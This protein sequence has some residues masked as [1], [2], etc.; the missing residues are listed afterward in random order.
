MG[1]T[2]E[3]SGIPW[4]AWKRLQLS[5]ADGGLGFR[6]LAKFNDALL[7][8]QAWRLL[9]YPNSLCARVLK[10]RYYLNDSILEAKP[11]SYQSFGWASILEGLD[12]IKKGT[13]HIVGD[14][15]LTQV[16][17]ENIL[18]SHPPRPI[19]TICPEL[20]FPIFRLISQHGTHRFLDERVISSMILPQDRTLLSQIHLSREV[21]PNYLIW[22]M[23]NRESIQSSR[24]IGS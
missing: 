22:N 9:R 23:I 15:H 13:R 18:G 7:A 8:K 24:V 10:A 5:K 6:D 14:G 17:K 16:N 20:K 21:S 3:K 19:R 1:K 11:R 12:L 4:I 2:N